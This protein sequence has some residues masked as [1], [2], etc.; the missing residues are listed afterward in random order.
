MNYEELF[1]DYLANR[2]T[3]EKTSEL[4]RVL[5]QDKQMRARFV[6]VLQEWE[7]M[8]VAARQ[9]TAN[10]SANLA[11]DVMDGSSNRT[12]QAE[13]ELSA[14]R[15]RLSLRVLPTRPAWR[16]VISMLIPASV[17]AA[18]IAVLVMLNVPTAGMPPLATLTASSGQVVIV[19]AN[20]KLVGKSGTLLFAGDQI[21]VSDDGLAT[22]SY[23]D[24]TELHI[25]QPSDIQLG[26]SGST[27][28]QTGKQ[29]VL[30]WGRVK[31]DVTKQPVG[32]PMLFTTPNAKAEVLGTALTL[33]YS[34]SLD[35]TR[36]EVDHG[37]VA[38]TDTKTSKRVEVP[39]GHYAMVMDKQVPIARL[40]HRSIEVTKEYRPGLRAEYFAGISFESSL[41]QRIESSISADIGFENR[42]IDLRNSDFSVRW[43][44]Y[45]QSLFSEKYMI[46]LR[47]DGGV[48]LYL[49]HQIII[50]AWSAERIGDHQAMVKL[51]A[52]KRHQLRVEYRQPKSGM[53]VRLSWASP[54][55]NPEVIPVERL[56]TDK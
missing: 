30:K 21:Q 26:T 56:S 34:E 53:L 18:S 13:A 32:E 19:R 15:R 44:G 55:Q 48:R 46:T 12:V 45:L 1:E 29:V 22:V 25:D 36:L 28:N 16:R 6:A 17:L 39:T 20:E 11:A 5:S 37:L 51:D 41:F 8:A 43:E 38:I 49:D 54:S 40:V 33:E 10:G 14:N 52:S 9:V 4:K 24:H 23:L 42:A 47:S 3:A 2:L 35:S 31:A 50:D 7:L 27:N